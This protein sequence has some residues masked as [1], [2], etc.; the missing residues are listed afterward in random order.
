MILVGSVVLVLL[1][2][3]WFTKN[4]DPAPLAG[5]V[6]DR[7]AAAHAIIYVSAGEPESEQEQQL[8]GPYWSELNII[9]CAVDTLKCEE[10]EITDW[11]TLVLPDFGVQIVGLQTMEDYQNLLVRLN[12]W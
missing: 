9:D 8:F 3:L 12:I 1:V 11:P 10:N 5:E 2:A 7:L 4:H 6:A